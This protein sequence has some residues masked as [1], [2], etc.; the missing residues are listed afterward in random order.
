MRQ[1][2]WYFHF[3]SPYAYFGL[4]KFEPLRA[5]LQINCRPVLFAD[6]PHHWDPR[7]PARAG[8]DSR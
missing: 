7:G 6:L 8:G 5:Q 3:T 2:N 1:A 4:H